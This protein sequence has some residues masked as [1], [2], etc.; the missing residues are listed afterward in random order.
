M[1]TLPADSDDMF[2]E[3]R[4]YAQILPQPL[5]SLFLIDIYKYYVNHALNHAATEL[6]VA[7]ESQEDEE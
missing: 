6:M 5:S 1:M 2:K 3:I 7:F 4:D